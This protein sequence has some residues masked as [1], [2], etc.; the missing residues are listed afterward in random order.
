MLAHQALDRFGADLCWTR[1]GITN[2]A[3]RGFCQFLLR[4]HSRKPLL[5]EVVRL[6]LT[7]LHQPVE[8]PQL[9]LRYR[10]LASQPRGRRH[11]PHA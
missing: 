4:P 10:E 9:L 1:T 6:V 3:E 5:Q 7:D 11:P 2:P 8:P